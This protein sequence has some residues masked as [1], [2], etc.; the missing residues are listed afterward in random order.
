M[1]HLRSIVNKKFKS[2][3][4]ICLLR[5]PLVQPRNIIS[6]HDFGIGG[7]EST[8]TVV[9]AVHLTMVELVSV[10]LL[11]TIYCTSGNLT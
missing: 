1:P 8:V 2:F 6:E 3:K 11:I 5:H 4:L 7:T 10:N 9:I